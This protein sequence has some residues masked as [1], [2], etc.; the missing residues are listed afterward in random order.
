MSTWVP[1]PHSPPLPL[2]PSSY[3]GRVLMQSPYPPPF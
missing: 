2:S 3:V 1:E